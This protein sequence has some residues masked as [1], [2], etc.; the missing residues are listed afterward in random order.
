MQ[1][2]SLWHQILLSSP[3]TS[4][5]ECCYRFDPVVSFFLLVLAFCSSPVAYWTPSTWAGVHLPMSHLFAFHTVHSHWVLTARIL[6]SFAVPSFS[7]PCFVRTL[8]YDL[9]F[10]IGIWSNHF[11]ENR[12]RKSAS[13]GRFYF[14]GLQNHCRQ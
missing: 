1:Y 5:I 4:T 10:L 6:E 2:C 14:L 3:E 8:Q 9:S 12:R 13:S 11:M 7:G